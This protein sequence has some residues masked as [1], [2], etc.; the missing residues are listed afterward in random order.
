MRTDRDSREPLQSRSP[1]KRA[2]ARHDDTPDTASAFR[3]LTRLPDGPE[4]SAVREEIIRAWIPVAERVTRRFRHRGESGEDLFQVAALGLVKA[5]DHY[6]PERGHAFAS[7]AIPTMVGE[8]KRHFRDHLWSLHVPRRFQELH[9]KTYLA[10]VELDQADPSRTPTPG[11]VAEQAG[12]TE[13]EA[14]A[15][16]AAHDAYRAASLDAPT[17]G[18]AGSSLTDVLGDDDHAFDLVVDRESLKPLLA[19]LPERQQRILYLRFF[20]ELTQSQIAEA[21]GVS[22]MQVSRLLRST[23]AQ[24]RRGLLAGV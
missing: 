4:R 11:E 14:A 23:C 3:R 7:F 19:D 22:Q 10:I 18:I 16:M 13:S 21:V 17:P 15:G 1:R 12:L 8:L 20:R 9:T 24:L 5:V 2:H 6:D